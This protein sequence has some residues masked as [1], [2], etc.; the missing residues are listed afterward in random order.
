M[1]RFAVI[2]VAV[3][4]LALCALAVGCDSESSSTYDV[5]VSWNVAGAQVCKTFITGGDQIDFD[6]VVINVYEKE[7]DTDPIQ[8]PIEVPCDDFTTTIPRLS[9]GDYFVTLGAMATYSNR[10]L[11]FYQAKGPISAP[12]EQDSGYEFTLVLGKGKIQASWH[13]NNDE[14]CDPNGVVSVDLSIG[15]QDPVECNTGKY[16]IEDVDMGVD[17]RLTIDGLDEGG[18][19]TWTGD[20]S[21]NP[22]EVLPGETIEAKVELSPVS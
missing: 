13:F 12:A 20:Y 4:L 11:P 17:Y 18:N 22:F 15:D 14:M 5:P 9:R 2:F 6:N 19:I 10:T 21:E 16:L 1:K 3:G 8:T 7:G